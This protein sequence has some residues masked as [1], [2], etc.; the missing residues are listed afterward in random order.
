MVT[1]EGP[2][3]KRTKASKSVVGDN[4]RILKDNL[5]KVSLTEIDWHPPTLAPF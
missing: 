2:I 5:L 1:Q 4:W 3:C